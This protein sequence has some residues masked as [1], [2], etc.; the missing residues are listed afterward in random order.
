MSDKKQKIL[1]S[2]K[3]FSA[4]LFDVQEEVLQDHNN[5]KHTFNTVYAKPVASVIPVTQKGEI[6]LI[7]QYR[8]LF[9]EY[10]LGI[11]SGFIEE[12]ETS[13]QAA[14]RE[15]KEEAGIEASQWEQIAKVT[16]MRSVVKH[17]VNIFIAK[18]LEISHQHLE[19][20]EDIELVKMSLEEAVQKVMSGEIYHSS[21]VTGILLLNEL[22]RKKQL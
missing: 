20:D 10:M 19:D 4:E 2:K 15:L 14:K 5:K 22:K 1:S 3:V 9:G 11:I 21:S 17:Y 7:K 12:N 16:V 6:Y 8:Y 18:D 13:L